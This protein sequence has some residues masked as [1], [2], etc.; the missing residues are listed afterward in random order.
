MSVSAS[1]SEKRPLIIAMGAARVLARPFAA[2]LLTG[3]LAGVRIPLPFTP[4]PLTGQVFGVLLAGH[5]LG[6]GKAA[7]AM[8]IYLAAGLAGLPWFS[9]W[10]ALSPAAFASFP[11]AGYLAGFLPAAWVIGKL[12][13]RRA[14]PG[15]AR[16][17]GAFLAGVAVIYALGALWLGLLMPGASGRLLAAAVYP[18]VIFDLLKVLLAMSL[19]APRA[20]GR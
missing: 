14:R 16:L 2:A 15:A 8:G 4:V 12:A 17:A 10:Q 6:A 1:L 19:L 7:A 13:P 3:I 20:G 9:G 5:F 11:A 18:F